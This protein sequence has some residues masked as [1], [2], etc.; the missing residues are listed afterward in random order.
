MPGSLRRLP[1]PWDPASAL[2]PS[3]PA[4]P[5]GQP[6]PVLGNGRHPTQPRP[7]RLAPLAPALPK[8]LSFLLWGAEGRKPRPDVGPPPPEERG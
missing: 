4:D 1:R 2:L 8:S 6:V 7:A 3:V 5:A